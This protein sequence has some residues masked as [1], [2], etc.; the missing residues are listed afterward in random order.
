MISLQTLLDVSGSALV[1]ISLIF[2]VHKNAWYWHFSNASLLPYFMLFVMTRQYMLAG[3]QLSYLIF[4]LHGLY[5]WRLER[6]RDRSSIHFN[7]VLWYNLGWVLT[8]AIFAYTVT[9]SDFSDSWTILQFLITSMSLVA[10][11]A[12]TR[13][14][15]WSWYLW[16]IVNAGQA[17]LFFHLGLWAQFALPGVLAAMSVWGIVVWRAEPATL[18]NA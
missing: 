10:N 5:L 3:L 12:T 1:A 7:E 18:K 14:F 6:L 4:G 9:Q 2:L 17:F 8:L 13:R 11:W 15:L 16:I